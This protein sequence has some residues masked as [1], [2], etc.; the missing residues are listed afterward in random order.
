M[1]RSSDAHLREVQ[2]LTLPLTHLKGVGPKRATLMAQ[3]GLRTILDLLFFT[4]VRYEDRTQISL[5]DEAE[6]GIPV[7]VKGRV[8]HG[9]EER[10]FASRKR[11]FRV[12]IEDEGSRLALLWFHYRK[13]HLS[14]YAS[15]G[16]GLLAYGTIQENRGQRQMI[17]PE[18]TI[19]R[20]DG[21][22]TV[23]SQL[24][25]YP[26]YSSVRGISAN[27]LR[28]MIREALNSY[29][30][31]L[32]D[33]IPRE[34]TRRLSLPDLAEAIRYV[35]FPSQRASLDH[36]DQ[37]NTPF[38]KRLLFDRFFLVMLTM[39]FRKKSKERRRSPILSVPPKHMEGIEGFF[40]FK[41][42]L[43]QTRAIEDV[44]KD[45]TAGKCMNR[46]I[47]GDVGC[48][49]T[50][51]AAAAAYFTVRNKH[52]V[53]LMVPTQE[54]ANQHFE[55]FRELS[56]KMGFHPVLLTAR[57]ARTERQDFYAKIRNGTFN[58]II[59]TQSL[60][61]E[62]LRFANLGLVIIDEQ[63]RFG[64]RDRALMDR[65]GEN[66]HILV[67]T[68]TPIPRTLAIAVYG[69][70][71]LSFIDGYPEGRMPVVT[72]L[73]EEDEKRMVFQILTQRMAAGEQAFV[74][75]PVIEGSEDMDLKNALD[76]TEKLGKIFAPRFRI[77]L[78][79]GR[80][81]PDEREEV[82]TNF[83]KGLIHLLV[84][85]TV[86]EVGVHVPT[87]TVM[88]IEHPERFGLSQLHQL[89]GRVGR[90]TQRGLCLLMLN[91]NLSERARSR[92]NI[93]VGHDNGFEIAKKDLALRGQGELIGMRQAGM[94]E[95]DPVEMMRDA[96]LLLTAKGEANRLVQ[97]DPDLSNAAN[98]QLKLMVESILTR[99]L[100][101]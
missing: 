44:A 91:K 15:P 36:L 86:I 92:L 94:G 58:L 33:P 101:L 21:P 3:K 24:G 39:A 83:R 7:L 65:K 60:I 63:Q 74:I 93:V 99:P 22:E 50:V 1:T 20:E 75:C 57:L 28:R 85:T 18:I 6:V 16:M 31:S 42:T 68:A 70:L 14:K 12:F 73:V 45:F 97:S 90:G 76:M 25:F 61:Q 72:K 79:H 66:L 100:D 56:D 81:S 53:A 43:H 82:M 98:E 29:L 5:I 32:I 84:G 34:I 17:H 11:I 67:M 88:V 23:R 78:V 62:G 40:P 52:Q 30:A 64:V 26:V 4:P 27:I 87:A 96:E 19:V 95:L 38:H 8:V 10:F 47:L 59:G 54:L 55:Y 51:V 89:R 49:K 69:D 46:L 80:L 2:K 71:D 41:L 48:G 37:F 77:G 13:P 9:R 35:H